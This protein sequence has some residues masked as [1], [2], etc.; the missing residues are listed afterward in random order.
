MLGA[1]LVGDRDGAESVLAVQPEDAPDD[2]RGDRVELELAI[3]EGVSEG[4][5]VPL[6]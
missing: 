3:V 1:E 5:G 4:D 6:K 2:W